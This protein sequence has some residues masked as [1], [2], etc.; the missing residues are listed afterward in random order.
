MEPWP[1]FRAATALQLLAVHPSP[2]LAVLVRDLAGDAPRP[3]EVRQA[4]KELAQQH[5]AIAEALRGAPA[6]AAALALVQVQVPFSL[7]TLEAI[8][9]AQ[10]EHANQL[11]SGRK[12]TVEELFAEDSVEEQILPHLTTH[13]RLSREGRPVYDVWE[14]MGDSGTIFEAGTTKV[15]AEIVQAHL[16]CGDATLRAQ[17][18][19]AL[20]AKKPATKKPPAKKPATKK[21]P[22]KKPATKKPA[23]KK[24][25]KPRGSS[26]RGRR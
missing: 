12:K 13:V 10:L 9:R 3:K 8:D 24:P 18:R 6:K 25:V 20:A 2:R 7:E 26:R 21:P 1:S 5:P 14:Y 19:G 11:Y 22:A 15:V 23:T 4:L 16:E 17:L